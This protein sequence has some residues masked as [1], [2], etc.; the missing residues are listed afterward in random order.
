M[1]LFLFLCLSYSLHTFPYLIISHI[2][3]L[4]VQSS[5]DLNHIMFSGASF[6]P[7]FKNWPIAYI[8]RSFVVQEPVYYNVHCDIIS[9][10]LKQP[11][12]VRVYV[13]WFNLICQSL[14]SIWYCYTFFPLS[15]FFLA[16]IFCFEHLPRIFFQLPSGE[17]TSQN[18]LFYTWFL[19]R[20]FFV[21]V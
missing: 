13:R 21:S 8:R 2:L 11:C 1:Y 17:K 9:N 19:F 12:L 4:Q 10:Y 16:P 6:C 14:R 5:L 15:Y 7:N 20:C 3:I 18:N